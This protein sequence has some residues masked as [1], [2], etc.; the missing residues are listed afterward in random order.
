MKPRK[1]SR[2]IISLN[3]ICKRYYITFPAK[4]IF[5]IEFRR[6]SKVKGG[7]KIL[8]DVSFKIERGELFVIQGESGSGKTTLLR[9]INRLEEATS[10]DILI[11]GKPIK[12]IPPLKLRREVVMVFQE[13]RLFQGTVLYNLTVAPKYHGIGVDVKRLLKEVGLEG[14][15]DRDAASLS[16][17]E[18]QRLALARALALKPKAILMDE[19]TSAL[20]EASREGIEEVII[21]LKE[22]RGATIVLVT[23]DPNQAKRLGERGIVLDKGRVVYDGEIVGMS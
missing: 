19:P 22:V 15:E 2:N 3:D 18:K 14:Y 10:G 4:F 8:D 9:L 12:N 16:G 7:K 17:G 1:N 5:M 6:V 13:P 23:H 11:Y 21:K 20:D